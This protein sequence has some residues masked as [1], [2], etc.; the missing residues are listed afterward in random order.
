MSIIASIM[1]LSACL[2]SIELSVSSVMLLSTFANMAAKFLLGPPTDTLGGKF[3]LQIS[4]FSMTILL[5]LLSFCQSSKLF[6]FQWILLSFLY[7]STWGAI[8]KIIRETFSKDKWSNQINYVAAASRFGNLL[9]AIV[10]GALVSRGFNW[11]FL[12]RGVG[13]VQGIVFIIFSLG[14]SVLDK[15]INININRYSETDNNSNNYNAQEETVAQVLKR[16]SQDKKF[17][18]MLLAKIPLMMV[19]QFIML[20]PLYLET[21]LKM[22]RS[23]AITKSSIFA[24]RLHIY[25]ICHIIMYNIFFYCI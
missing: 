15:N 19:G 9:S 23:A 7:S 4:M 3:T 13:C 14:Y 20:I 12:F 16:A 5:I 8:Q 25:C 10:Y 24:V 17:L 2:S 21:G 6:I 1:V 11:R 18:Y 22:T